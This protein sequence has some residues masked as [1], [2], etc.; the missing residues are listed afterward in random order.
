[1]IHKKTILITALGVL[2]PVVLISGLYYAYLITPPPM[3]ETFDQAVDTMESARFKRLPD[4]RKAEYAGQARRLFGELPPERQ[5]E[6]R[7]QMGDDE[8]MGKV[9]REMQRGRAAEVHKK[10]S[11]ASRADRF[12]MLDEQIDQQEAERARREQ[13]AREAPQRPSPRERAAQR[14]QGTQRAR[15]IV[16]GMVQQDNPQTGV[17]GLG[18]EYKRA[19]RKRRK[20]RGL[21]TPY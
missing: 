7:K 4:Y 9:A 8:T 18:A 10:Y 5:E 1:M 17:F 2:A 13:A 20:Q 16:R 11:Q 6:I 15:T 12:K 14:Q 21:E 3:P 19:L